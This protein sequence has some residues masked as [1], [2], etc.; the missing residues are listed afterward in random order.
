MRISEYVKNAIIDAARSSDP[1][2]RVWLFG[3]RIDD[4]KKGGDIDIAVLS[5]KI[6]NDVMQ[7]IHIRRSICDKIGDQRID[8]A[9]SADGMEAFF[10]LAVEEGIELI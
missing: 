7:K 1:E 4:N 10:R 9:T 5:K 6:N 2:A 8:I 3:S